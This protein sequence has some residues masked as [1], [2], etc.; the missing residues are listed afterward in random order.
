MVFRTIEFFYSQKT[1]IFNDIR[2]NL[3][4]GKENSK[5]SNT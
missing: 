2:H 1:L 4:L 5:Y 3:F